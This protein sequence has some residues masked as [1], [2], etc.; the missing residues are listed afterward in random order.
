MQRSSLLKEAARLMNLSV[1][2]E[3]SKSTT[4]TGIYEAR[5]VK[6]G[7][8]VSLADIATS[9]F[10][11]FH[12]FTRIEEN[13]LLQHEYDT[14]MVPYKTQIPGFITST[15]LYISSNQDFLTM[16]CLLLLIDALKKWSKYIEISSFGKG[17]KS[18]TDH[19][20]GLWKSNR[21]SV[22]IVKVNEFSS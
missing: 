20:L 19:C 3:E 22:S 16:V 21:F 6:D 5:L 9:A 1:V 8:A 2:S 18:A 15:Y 11:F 13:C 14:V 7:T 4:K 17:I 12:K 10:P